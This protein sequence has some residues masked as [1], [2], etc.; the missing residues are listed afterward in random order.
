MHFNFAYGDVIVDAILNQS[1]NDAH[2]KHSHI[3]L[4]QDN[5]DQ[6][7]SNVDTN[8]ETFRQNNPEIL[9]LFHD[10]ANIGKEL[11]SKSLVY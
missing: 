2:K 4:K 3:Q 10:N 11:K 5:L 6:Y 7:I 1:K 9:S 8:L